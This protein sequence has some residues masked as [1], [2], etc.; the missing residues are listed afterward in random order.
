[1]PRARSAVVG[2]ITTPIGISTTFPTTQNPLGSGW[3]QGLQDA[4]DWNNMQSS[5]GSP[6]TCYGTAISPSGFDDNIACRSGLSA[7][8]HYAEGDV[9]RVNGYAPG[10]NHEIELHVGTTISGHNITSYE[11]DWPLGSTSCD[12]LR[13]DGAVGSF[14]GPLA[15]S[16]TVSA[17]VT[18]DTIRAE[19]TV[20]GGS[21]TIVVKFNNST[22]LT[23]TDT[24][25]GKLTTGQMAGLGAFGRTGATLSSYGWQR[26]ACGN[27]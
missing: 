12:L 9:F 25:A 15:T 17:P 21:P 19:Y 22:I 8:A 26:F 14:T 5:G 1:M 11:I 6:G 7:T 3:I 2:V 24:S 10:V 20:S 16:S 23:Y 27:L 4:L 13:W 18:G